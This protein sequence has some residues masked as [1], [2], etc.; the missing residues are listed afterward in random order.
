MLKYSVIPREIKESLPLSTSCLGIS[1]KLKKRVINPSL[2]VV[3]G[4]RKSKERIKMTRR[5]GLR[6]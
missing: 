2:P 4:V 3:R 6:I 1:D 5:G